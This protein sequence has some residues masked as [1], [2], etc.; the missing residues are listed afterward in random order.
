MRHRR[1]R[2]PTILILAVLVA[3]SAGGLAQVA[4][5]VFGASLSAFPGYSQEGSTITLVLT[6]GGATGNTTYE[7]QFLVTD[8]STKVWTSNPETITTGLSQTEFAIIISYPSGEFPNGASTSLVG[9]YHVQVNMVKPFAQSSVAPPRV[10][11]VGLTDKIVPYQRTETVGIFGTGYLA[12]ELVT[13]TIRTAST[14]TLVHNIT[15]AAST[16]GQVSDS[17]KIPKNTVQDQYVVTLQGSFTA[18]SPS[19]AQGFTVQAALV[20][21]TSLAPGQPTFQRTQTMQF[22]FSLVYP[23]GEP[24]NTGSGLVTLTRPDRT[25]I[26]LTTAYNDATQSF[27]AR[28]AT[29]T[30]DQVG[31]WTAS[32]ASYIFDDGFGNTGPS[33]PTSTTTQLQAA[34]LWVTVTVKTYFR[35]NEMIAFNATI[36]YPDMTS[37]TSGNVT[38]TLSFSGGGYTRNV[39]VIFDTALSLWIGT[40]TPQGNEPGGLWSLT[41]SAHDTATPWNPGTTTRVITLQD[42]PPVAGTISSPSNTALTGASVSFTS[43]G[44]SDPDGTIVGYTWVFGDGSTGTGPNVSHSYANPG[45]FTVKLTVTD[46]SNS[47]ASSNIL[48]LTIQAAPP[49]EQPEPTGNQSL[50]LFLFGILATIIAALLGGGVLLFR[51]HKVTHAK[52][53]ID[54]EAVRSEAGRIENQEFFQSVKEQ[55]KKEKGE[56]E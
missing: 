19:D 56:S 52:L 45:T 11:Y 31:Q 36:Q 12:G 25:N 37:L 7:F 15:V 27:V 50:P 43:S 42:R 29:K 44:A 1:M 34:T 17:W 22:S 6:V 48:S 3:L 9:G 30:T 2:F 24:V 40:Y 35:A 23:S 39:P 53:K 46:N 21:V 13:V 4:Y 49:T 32:L 38:S 20:K 18:K 28:Y 55:L 10:F 33:T 54:I 16:S 14:L 47:T 5:A 26:T 51:R 8:P 41:V